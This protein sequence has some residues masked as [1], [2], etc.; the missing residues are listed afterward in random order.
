MMGERG[1][2]NPPSG[3]SLVIPISEWGLHIGSFHVFFHLGA[4][5]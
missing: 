4:K 3:D 2:W 1:G 5:G